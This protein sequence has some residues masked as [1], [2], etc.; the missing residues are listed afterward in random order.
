M[1]IKFDL[2]VH[3][4]DAIVT[5]A[6]MNMSTGPLD[7]SLGAHITIKVQSS[8]KSMVYSLARVS[9]VGRGLHV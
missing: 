1:F 3:F 8:R 5:T 7:D 2:S 4:T 9:G 6:A